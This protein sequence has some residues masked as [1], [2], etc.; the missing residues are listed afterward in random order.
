MGDAT[1]RLQIMIT[2]EASSGSQ[3]NAAAQGKCG[4]NGLSTQR[5]NSCGIVATTMG[6]SDG[7]AIVGQV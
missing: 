7:N 4:V 5:G 3:G 1:P 6:H 2:C